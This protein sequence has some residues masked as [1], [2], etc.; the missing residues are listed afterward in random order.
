MTYGDLAHSNNHGATLSDLIWA[1][2]LRSTPKLVLLRCAC[3]AQG[4]GTGVF[5]SV[6]A[7][8]AA[9]SA[10]L[11]TIRGAI[12]D[13]VALGVLVLVAKED[14]V[15]HRPREYRIDL[16]RLM[17]MIPPS[18]FLPPPRKEFAPSPQ[19]SCPPPPQEICPIPAK[20]LRLKSL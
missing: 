12:A 15:T 3:Y 1:S 20:I 9:C 13:L 17:A 7:V 2:S 16:D 19:N 11:P 5:P 14:P 8:A 10:T 6:A 18:N 4:D